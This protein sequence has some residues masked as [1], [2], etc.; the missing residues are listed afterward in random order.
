MACLGIIKLG[1]TRI[2]VPALPHE[3]QKHEC[4]RVDGRHIA[5][6]VLERHGG[7]VP[8]VDHGWVVAERYQVTL[9]CINA[10]A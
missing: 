8:S 3:A 6:R 4:D 2:I 5:A 7:T 9:T 10:V 1:M